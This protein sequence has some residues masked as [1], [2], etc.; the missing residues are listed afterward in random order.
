MSDPIDSRLRALARAL[1]AD[2]QPGAIVGDPT[3][4][5]YLDLRAPE[6]RHP[7]GRVLIAAAAVAALLVAGGLAARQAR[8]ST[9]DI[10]AASGL[11]A[12]TTVPAVVP[13]E[14]AAALLD[15]GYQLTRG[16]SDD[17]TQNS[18]SAITA[19]DVP[20]D[21]IGADDALAAVPPSPCGGLPECIDPPFTVARL[22]RYQGFGGYD[23]F[24]DVSGPGAG[25][26]R[27]DTVVWVLVR[28]DD[29]LALAGRPGNHVMVPAILIDASSGELV[30]AGALLPAS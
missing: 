28:S 9:S 17:A 25:D 26:I 12:P 10:D 3:D 1:V 19:A 18:I 23:G 22:A 21:A 8:P 30:G 5:S 15:G 29:D 13:V 24:E 20:L 6:R 14:P 16:S 2:G 4:V 27:L 11:V 7:R